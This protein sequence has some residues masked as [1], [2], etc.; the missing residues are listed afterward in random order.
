M[1]KLELWSGTDAASTEG[2]SRRI[3]MHVRMLVVSGITAWRGQL[4]A[5]GVYLNGRSP[6]E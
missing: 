2:K 4:G 1:I 6:S 5:I 3:S